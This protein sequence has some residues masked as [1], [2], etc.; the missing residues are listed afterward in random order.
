[1]H[2]EEKLIE[3]VCENV[4]KT[5]ELS[6]NEKLK[7]Y[8]V[9]GKRFKNALKA[10]DEKAVK[11]YVFRPSGRVVWIVVGKERDYEV[12]PLIGY[13]S[14][15]DFYFRV[16]SSDIFSCYHII[17]QKLAEVL[18]KYEIIEEEDSLYEVLMKEWRFISKQD[19]PD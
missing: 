11:K 4:R 10:L 15:D 9:F 8:R 7:L 3:E 18:G 1:M 12:I 16:L 19:I 2:E 17:A 14:C 6:E 13:C 5:G